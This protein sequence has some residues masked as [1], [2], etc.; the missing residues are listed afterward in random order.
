MYNVSDSQSCG[1][2]ELSLHISGKHEK[3]CL[4]NVVQTNFDFKSK[5]YYRS[6]LV[7]DQAS[8]LVSLGLDPNYRTVFEC[9]SK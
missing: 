9:K 4:N 7:Q 6:V 5:S 8:V 1:S 2:C 3:T